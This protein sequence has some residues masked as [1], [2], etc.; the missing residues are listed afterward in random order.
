[1]EWVDHQ[2]FGG[3]GGLTHVQLDGF[4]SFVSSAPG[5]VGADAV[6]NKTGI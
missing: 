4:L 1:M 5:R 3:G 2:H 6:E